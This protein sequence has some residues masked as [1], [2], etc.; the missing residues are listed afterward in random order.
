MIATKQLPDNFIRWNGKQGAP[1]GRHLNPCATL[2]LPR[3][4]IERYNDRYGGPYAIQP[5][6]TTRLFEYPWAFH[7]T[8][9]EP[10]Q[11]VLEIGGGLGGF[12]FSLDSYGCRVINVDPGLEAK[13]IGWRCDNHSMAKLNYLFGTSVELRN[14]T[15]TGA[16]L[17]PASFDRIFSISVMEH[18]PA[19]E[20]RDAMRI[21]FDCLKPGGYFILTVD[22]FINLAPFTSRQSNVFGRNID[23]KCLIEMAP[24]ALAQGNPDELYGF[25]EF[26][27]DRIQSSLEKFMIGAH[28]P[29]LAQCFVLQKR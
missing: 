6:N 15:I 2:L 16:A 21:A 3:F 24:F 26:D 14:T 12:Q 10:D 9:L 20:V 11:R 7:A 13:G 25:P 23:V 17:E 4:I 29:A 1:F 28:Y 5:N 8:P 22:L 27:A 19:D 18:L